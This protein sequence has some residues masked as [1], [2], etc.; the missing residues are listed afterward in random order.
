MLA[1][2]RAMVAIQCYGVMHQKILLLHRAIFLIENVP[3]LHI[4][5]LHQLKDIE[6]SPLLVMQNIGLTIPITQ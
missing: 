1:N 3:H 2:D 4:G 5:T 6:I